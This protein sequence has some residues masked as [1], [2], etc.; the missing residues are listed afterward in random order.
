MAR[1]RRKRNYRR[2]R[3]FRKNYRKK[4]KNNRYIQTYN[5]LKNM[6]MAPR[7][8]CKFHTDVQFAVNGSSNFRFTPKMNSVYFPY[9]GGGFDHS[10]VENFQPETPDTLE[11][12]GFVQICNQGL[13]SNWRVFASKIKVTMMPQS[14]ID[15]MRVSIT[16]SFGN[17]PLNAA[18]A[19]AQ[20]YTRS[21]MI[22]A[23][24]G[25]HTLSNYIKTATLMGVSPRAISYD[26]SGQNTGRYDIDIANLATWKIQTDSVD[27]VVNETRILF[28]VK[29]T[30]YVELFSNSS[31]TME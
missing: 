5:G 22:S 31:A 29:M 17:E 23:Y 15:P 16:P 19:S 28:V 3:I 10:A 8:R 6:I 9:A 24:N 2:K 4:V 7:Y 11:P 26:L 20:P 14:I 30:H 27:N 1:P 25:S 13:Y 12:V 21:R 18:D